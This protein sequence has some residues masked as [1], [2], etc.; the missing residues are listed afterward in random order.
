MRPSAD[1]GHV[2]HDYQLSVAGEIVKAWQNWL[3]REGLLSENRPEE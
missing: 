1:A 2:R 3:R